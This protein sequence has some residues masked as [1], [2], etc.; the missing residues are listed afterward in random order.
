MRLPLHS[1][2]D[3]IIVQYNLLALASY[4]WVYPDIQKDMPGLNQYVII[5]NNHL[6]LHLSKHGYAPI[7]RTP[8]LW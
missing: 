1:I 2:L 3:E 4:G 6:T 8:S 5:F 7:P